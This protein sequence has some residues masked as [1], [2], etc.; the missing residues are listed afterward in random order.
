MASASPHDTSKQQQQQH[1]K[2]AL[3][4]HPKNKKKVPHLRQTHACVRGTSERVSIITRYKASN[5][6]S[7]TRTKHYTY[8]KKKKKVLHLGHNARVPSTGPLSLEP[9][10]V[11]L[12]NKSDM[13]VQTPSKMRG[14][15]SQNNRAKPLQTTSLD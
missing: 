1:Q 3:H 6:S 9:L 5:N 11:P 10:S 14:R 13:G 2:Q 4:V 15:H 8:T 7:S 12:K